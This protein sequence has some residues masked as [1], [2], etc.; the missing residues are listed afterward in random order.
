MEARS[1]KATKKN[2]ENELKCFKTPRTRDNKK[3]T[4][5]KKDE[6]KRKKNTE[7]QL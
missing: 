1:L 3:I 6:E 4:V 7:N 5:R 2:A